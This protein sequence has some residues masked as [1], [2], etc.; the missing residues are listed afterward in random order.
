MRRVV[1]C[2]A[3]LCA[4]VL[5]APATA[6]AQ[7]G[8]AGVVR[9][10]TGAVMPGVTVEASSPALIEKSRV[11]ISDSAGQYKIVDLPPGTYA[12][13]FTLAGFKSVRRTDILL[14]GTFTAQ[15]NADLQV[16]AMEETLTV[17]A[18]SPTVDVITNQKTFVA[19]R[20]ILDSIPTPVRN[21]PGRA[22]LIP[23]TTVTPFV[24][25]QFNLT[26]HGSA[27]SDFAM[28]ID[29]LRVNNLCGSGQYSGFYMNDAAVQ[30]LSYA[31][32]SES[33]EIQSSGIRVNQVPKDG[34][35]RFSGSFFAQYQGSGLQ[36]DNRTDAM[37]AVQA[38]GLPLIT[39]AG[40]AFNYQLN[41]SFGGPLMKDKLWFY[42]TYKYEDGKIYVPSA[43]FA[44]GSQAYRNLMG[45]YSGIGRV[46]WAASGKDKIRAY[47]EKQF[48]GE[49]YNGFNTLA[50]STPEASTD[51]FGIGWIPQVRWT[52]AQSSKL[53]FEAGLAYYNQPY[54][55]NCSRTQTN[56]TALPKLNGSTGLLTGRCG[57]LIPEYSSTTKDYNVL[58]TASY[59]TGS[60]AMKFGVTDL[61]GENSR[62]FAP[63]ANINTL[64]TVNTVIPGT[65]IPL[66]DFPFQVSVYNSP[67]TAFQNVNSDIG[68]FGQDTWTMK[69]LTFNYGARYEH[70]NASIPA[71]SSP[72][73]TW[74]GARNFPEIPNVPNWDDW[75]VRLAIAYDV[76]GDGKTAFKAN[77]GK[78][79]AAQAAGLAQ[80]FN[81]M[82]GTLAGVPQ[83]RTWNDANGDKTIMNADG[84]IQT[85]EVI[86]GTSNFGQ[87][88]SR[89]DPDLPRGYNWEY[90]AIIQRELRPRVSVTAGYY[91][92]D[93]YNLQVT[94]NLSVGVNDWTS[95][96]INT[97]V[98]TRLPLSG[99]PIP[100]F[101]L[102]TGKV[103]V[104]TDN[105]VTFSTQ[106]KTTY[107]GVEFTMNARGA[108]YLMFGGVTTDRRASATCDERD[109]PN[110]ARFCD[111][112]PPF[113]TTVKLS[114]A[115]TFPYD[116]QVSGSFASIPG[117]GV[118]ANY[119][120]T[121][122]IANRPIIGSTAGAA[123][124][125]VN[126]VESG[127]LFLDKQNRL[128][129]RLGKTF[130]L[131]RYRIQ[132]FADVFNV[133]NAGT[134]IRVNETFAASGTNQW[135]TPTGILEGRYVRF[136]LQMSF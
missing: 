18:E 59:V 51:A 103:G 136:G 54:E 88:T 67:A 41:P 15:I 58:A 129:L 25:G 73:S 105:L 70:F 20:E 44:D 119:T 37:K 10:T 107:N 5:L 17:T 63:R 128:D 21:T 126:L 7:T 65:T 130:R 120:V 110:S 35:N 131:D 113:R 72:A 111:S 125:V 52:R 3:V 62:T 83:T 29:G 26:S 92:R 34:G 95:Y 19:N 101:T 71:E 115:Y 36:S 50:T 133:F 122:A 79:V 47:I 108:K 23:G 135:L 40:T 30:E 96:S 49:F 33:A 116:I 94:D 121:S 99:Q 42:L 68:V 85:N 100:M 38:N 76:F 53:L 109:N 84:S 123:S 57:Y 28:A 117:P 78:Y 102:N 16:G 112:F 14:E 90:S 81:G 75:A 134:V 11:A 69:R 104:A 118:S 1:I 27:T 2:M 55:Q 12:V 8:I 48:N 45:Q 74:I 9:D 97:P 87:L 93:F 127:T 98:D 89:P 132:G 60:H 91:R 32:G 86:G 77:A 43:R 82:S 80:T 106:N 22:L 61:W 4:G 66:I 39:I 64:I 6:S 46:T 114:G 124:T 31:T 13:A 56:P 24:L